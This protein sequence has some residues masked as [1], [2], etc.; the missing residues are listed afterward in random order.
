MTGERKSIHGEWSSRWAFILAAAGSAIGLGN[1]WK[2]PYLAGMNGGGAFVLVYLVTALVIAVPIMMAEIMLGRRGRR[3]PINTMRTLAH[4]AKA[5]R[6]WY[7]LGGAGIVAGFLILSYYS[8]I[9]GWAVAYVFKAAFGTFAGAG[10]ERAH[11]IFTQFIGSP[12]LLLLWHTVVMIATMIVVARGVKSGLEQAV[13]WMMPA[14]FITLFVL[15]GYAM[16][17][18]GFVQ[19]LAFLFAPDFSKISGEGILAA[20]GQAFFSLS[21]GM[22]A[23]MMYGSYLKSHV[24]IAQTAIIVAGMDTFVAVLAGIA[25]FPLVFTYGLPVGSGPGLIFETLPIAFGQMPGGPFFGALFF[26]LLVFAAWTST[27]SLIEPAVAWLVENR[28][29][30]RWRACGVAGFATWL[31]GVA[32]VLSFNTW[33]DFKIFG[34]TPFDLIDFLTSNL[35]LPLGGLLI[36][37][38]AG[39]IMSP[40]IARKEMAMKHHGW[41]QVWHF[42]ARYVAPVGI[43][44]VFL[45]V[46]DV[47]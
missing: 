9:A 2:F 39:W 11:A 29:L 7:L 34:K 32:T 42:L 30:S 23:I 20:M 8:V 26:M 17:S 33:S 12:W 47:I 18:A 43:A 24:S 6:W 28:G 37:V 1:I 46:I 5:S 10:T 15:V 3:S 27:I 22:G 16:S 35:M 45:N 40:N 14:L 19:G 38:F 31:L 21:L 44:L 36:A 4:E 13:R 25:I 41:Y